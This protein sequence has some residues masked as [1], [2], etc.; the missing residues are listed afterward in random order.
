V[1]DLA[2]TFDPALNLERTRWTS[3]SGATSRQCQA[4]FLAISNP[5]IYGDRSCG[6]HAF[7]SSH[8]YSLA[9]LYKQRWNDGLEEKSGTTPVLHKKWRATCMKNGHPFCFLTR[10]VHQKLNTRLAP[11]R[12]LIAWSF[13]RVPGTKPYLA[14]LAEIGGGVLVPVLASGLLISDCNTIGTPLEQATSL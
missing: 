12:T 4:S 10:V 2:Q 1:Y 11:C 6:Q 7:T 14:D 8:P 9:A 5:V 3:I 13:G